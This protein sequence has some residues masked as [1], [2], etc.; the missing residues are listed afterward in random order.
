MRQPGIILSLLFVVF[1]LPA[2]GAEPALSAEEQAYIDKVEKIWAT[3]ETRRGNIDLAG[4]VA[5]LEVPDSFY[6]LD[7]QQAEKLLTDIWE[8]PPGSGSSTLGVLI[9]RDFHPLADESW[10][11]TI[12]YEP[13]G[14]VSDEEAD[15]IDYDD[16]LEVMQESTAEASKARVAQGYEAIELVGWAAEPFYDKAT[17]KMHWAKEIRF[18]NADYGTLN[19]NIRVLGRKGVLVVNFIALMDQLPAINQ[20][21]DT[22]LAIADFDQG[23][24]YEDFDPDIDKVA[25]YGIGALVTGKV[26]A[27]TGILAALLVF[28]KKFGV[29]IV[30]AGA[31]F[32]G[33]LFKRD[34]TPAS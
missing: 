16:L 33:R 20:Q 21:L 32:I 31:A 22:V 7:P 12:F 6:Y 27:K 23:S 11:A 8:N 10:A 34:K 29:F 18:G 30:V 26:L 17:H 25:A 5:K 3:V 19:Y 9:P 1:A 28:L 2:S 24:R 14:Y 15:R 4:G 13:D